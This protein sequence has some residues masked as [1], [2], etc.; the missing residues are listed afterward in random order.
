MKTNKISQVVG[1]ISFCLFVAIG[2]GSSIGMGIDTIYRRFNP[3]VKTVTQP[4]QSRDYDGDDKVEII[5]VRATDAKANGITIPAGSIRDTAE[6][7]IKYLSQ[8]FPD[9]YYAAGEY[10]NK[11]QSLK[12]KQGCLF[13]YN[14][15]KKAIETAIQLTTDQKDDDGKIIPASGDE[16]FSIWHNGKKLHTYGNWKVAK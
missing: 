2:I 15:K 16:N 4:L 1:V 5:Y 3:E 6:I 7:D 13:A 10:T 9:E 11:C 12:G 14:S 8:I